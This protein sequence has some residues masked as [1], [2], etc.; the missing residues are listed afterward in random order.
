MEDYR[1]LVAAE[2]RKFSLGESSLFLINSRE[3][4]LIDASLKENEITVKRLEAIATLYNVL[5]ISE[6]PGENFN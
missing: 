5:G 4:K 2:E 3:Q 6:E 1:T